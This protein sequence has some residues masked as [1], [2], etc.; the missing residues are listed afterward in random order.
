MTLEYFPSV[1]FPSICFLTFQQ[2]FF[3]GCMAWGQHVDSPLVDW[4]F[5]LEQP[6]TELTESGWSNWDLSKIHLFDGKKKKVSHKWFV[7][8]RLLFNFF[9]FQKDHINCTVHSMLIA[10][11][12][13][14]CNLYRFPAGKFLESVT[15][16]LCLG[17]CSVMFPDLW[18]A[19]VPGVWGKRRIPPVLGGGKNSLKSQLSQLAAMLRCHVDR[20]RPPAIDRSNSVQENG[21]LQRE[22]CL[23]CLHTNSFQSH[24]SKIEEILVIFM[25]CACTN[26]M[27]WFRSWVLIIP[28][29]HFLQCKIESTVN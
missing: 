15:S 8:Y 21:D 6:A 13:H 17:R 3:W 20:M 14:T 16:K 1:F 2:P 24:S 23:R 26:K 12:G 28:F 7:H 25:M 10:I 9:L 11:L 29:N 22:R 4:I 5:S 19:E 18:C 27:V